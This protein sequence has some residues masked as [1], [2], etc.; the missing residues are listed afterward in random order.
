MVALR[1]EEDWVLLGQAGYAV[2]AITEQVER[3]CNSENFAASDGLHK[4]LAFLV[5]EA[6]SGRVPTAADI[7]K[8]FRAKGTYGY[9][10]TGRVRAKLRD[11][12]ATTRG[13]RDDIQLVLLP[14][15]YIL[16]ARRNAAESSGTDIPP[17][18]YILE[19]ADNSENPGGVTV[20]GKIH[21]LDP[22]LRVWLIVR[23][24]DGV[25]YLQGRISRRSPTF[26]MTTRT[27][28]MQTG[29]HEGTVFEIL[30]VSA[31]ADADYHFHGNMPR[32]DEGFGQKLPEDT[33]VLASITVIRR[34][35]PRRN[36]KRGRVLPESTA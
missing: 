32:C 30:L 28:R 10:T 19:P 14:K 23:D 7:N 2:T 25:Y 17:K 1:R 15:S 34:D 6:L 11:Y 21:S 33:F 12:Y 4:N 26:Q 29:R 5:N 22:D 24:Q 13:R 36:F 20:R 9:T 3:I 16:V 35:I 27:G 8:E 18:A 31:D